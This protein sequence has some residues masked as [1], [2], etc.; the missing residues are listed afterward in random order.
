MI[1]RTI[2]RKKVRARLDC[3]YTSAHGCS[4]QVVHEAGSARSNQC[5]ARHHQDW[6]G[7]PDRK[8]PSASSV[9]DEHTRIAFIV[10]SEPAVSPSP[11]DRVREP[12]RDERLPCLLKINAHIRCACGV[13]SKGFNRQ[14]SVEPL[15]TTTFFDKF[16]NDRIRAYLIYSYMTLPTRSQQ[17]R[18]SVLLTV[19]LIDSGGTDPT[20]SA[21]AGHVSTHYY[22][23]SN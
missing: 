20:I 10:I 7:D 18:Q 5:V 22:H 1:T 13:Q 17:K 16:D 19:V 2:S 9:L 3:N 21:S 12:V 11:T 23:G 4:K 15:V 8:L 14:S 6:E